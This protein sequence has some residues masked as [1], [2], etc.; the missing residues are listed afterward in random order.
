MITPATRR[1]VTALI[2]KYERDGHAACRRD[3]RKGKT[4][5]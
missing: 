4:H 3:M 5:V 1:K 2:R